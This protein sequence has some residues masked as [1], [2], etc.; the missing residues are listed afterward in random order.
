MSIT[1]TDLTARGIQRSL[2][3]GCIKIKHLAGCTVHF[4]C[5]WLYADSEHRAH[6]VRKLQ[7]GNS[8]V[9]GAASGTSN[10]EFSASKG[11]AR[12]YQPSMSSTVST[13]QKRGTVHPKKPAQTRVGQSDAHAVEDT[14]VGPGRTGAGIDFDKLIDLKLQ[15]H[16]ETPAAA[17]STKLHKC[18]TCNRQF[19]A[20]A[21]A[22]HRAVCA[23]VFASKRLP[24]DMT[25][26]RLSGI[27]ETAQHR[28]RSGTSSYVDKTRKRAAAG[29]PGALGSRSTAVMDERP[30]AAEILSRAGK[31]KQQSQ[32]LRA[33]MSSNRYVNF[34]FC[35]ACAYRFS[36]HGLPLSHRQ[37]F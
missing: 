25:Q 17:V 35:S 10:H 1:T 14:P 7:V 6:A 36:A 37:C 3:M 22:K 20:E 31:W 11:A 15:E 26:Q 19:T 30:A 33:A 5:F 2:R 29:R 8:L 27:A 4:K 21:L 13:A 16:G 34:M 23:K 12:E 18:G 32:Q 24:M 28:A 9:D